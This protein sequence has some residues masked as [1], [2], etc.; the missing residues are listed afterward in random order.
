LTSGTAVRV[1]SVDEDSPA[2]RAQMFA[3][4][5]I[6]SFNGSLIRTID[7]LLGHLTEKEI[8]LTSTLAILRLGELRQKPIVP[9]ELKE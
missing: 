8:G 6:I 2:A 4:D 5:V 3:G 7:D 9:V 1:I